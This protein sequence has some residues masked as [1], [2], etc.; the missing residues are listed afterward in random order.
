MI[1]VSWAI[2]ILKKCGFL[3]TSVC[4]DRL[5]S[6]N[7]IGLIGAADH[8]YTAQQAG[9]PV[10]IGVLEMCSQTLTIFPEF[11]DLN[12]RRFSGV[13]RKAIVEAPWLLESG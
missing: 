10:I 5:T 12:S 1:A 7:E 3:T 11:I 4:I 13:W 9:H 2:S 6:F 8:A